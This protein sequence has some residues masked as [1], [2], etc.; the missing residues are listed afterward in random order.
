MPPIT[1]LE[2]L[3]VEEAE[4]SFYSFPRTVSIEFLRVLGN[5]IGG[6]RFYG[7][8][9]VSFSVSERN[10]R[11][12]ISDL[13]FVFGGSFSSNDYFIFVE[14]RAFCVFFFNLV[15]S[16][17]KTLRKIPDFVFSLSKEE[18]IAF[19]ISFISC[20]S[21]GDSEDV[22][23]FFLSKN[24]FEG[25]KKLLCEF[26]ISPIRVYFSDAVYAAVISREAL[27]KIHFSETQPCFTYDE[28]V[29]LT[30]RGAK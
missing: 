9:K 6:L 26:E 29:E 5:A 27:R 13:V 14:D 19:L 16:R 12:F 8:K 4:S 3:P 7:D 2:P 25:I 1:W 24:V 28:F 15:G 17:Y 20:S 30:K 11:E 23:V 21:A 18:K 22:R 10:Q